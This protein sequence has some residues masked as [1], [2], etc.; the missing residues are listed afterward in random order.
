SST[1]RPKSSPWVPAAGLRI[2]MLFV[3]VSVAAGFGVHPRHLNN[4]IGFSR[5][6]CR[7]FDYDLGGEC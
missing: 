4:F 3:V 7:N 6:V 2:E 5:R 1:S